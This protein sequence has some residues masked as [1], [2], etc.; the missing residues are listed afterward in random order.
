[1]W[2]SAAWDGQLSG[3]LR[4]VQQFDMNRA[5]AQMTWDWFNPSKPRPPLVEYI[6]DRDLWRF[7]LPMS[8]EINAY[9]GA[10]AYNFTGW[11][12]LDHSLALDLDLVSRVGGV[13]DSKHQRDIAELLKASQRRMTIAG[14]D[15]PVAT[16]P[17]KMASDACPAMSKAEPSAPFAATYM[18]LPHGRVFSLRSTTVDVSEIAKRYGGGGHPGAAGFTMPLGWEGDP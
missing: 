1:M 8:R 13:I 18:D 10:H 15:V 14:H 4:I 11:D 12:Q 7:A 3:S 16:L 17:Y 9:L 6:S 5:G 2:A